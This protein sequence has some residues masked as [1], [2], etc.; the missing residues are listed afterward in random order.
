MYKDFL[1]NKIKN[2]K[3]AA[4]I[5]LLIFVFFITFSVVLGI[6]APMLKEF[7]VAENSIK[8]KQSYF[9]AE[10]GIEDAAYR[11]KNTMQIDSSENI[12]LGTNSVTTTITDIGNNQ[13]QILS[14]GDV[15]NRE[16]K[17]NM[18]LNTA[19]GV[20]FNYGVQ[21]GQGGLEFNGGSINGNV[22]SNGPIYGNGWS[23]IT[24]SATS[25][26][27][28]S[29]TTDQSNGSGTPTYNV[30]FA[31][32][33]AEQDVAQSFKI[34]N[35][36][37][38]ISKTTLYIKKNGAPS[39][40][41][42][43]I[44]NDSSGNPGSTVITSGTLSAST[45]STSYG[46]VEVSFDSN[47]LLSLNTTY[48]LVI[49]ASNNNSKYYTI[50]AS[51]NNY[52][53]GVGKIGRLGSSWSTP[54]TMD[55]F[56]NIF[57]GG[58]TG[59]IQSTAGQWNPIPIS[60]DTRAHNV[61][62]TNTTGTI[63]CTVDGGNNKPCNSTQPDPVYEAF[64][65][66]DTNIL[67]WK[68]EAEAGGTL[69]GNQSVG[70]AGATWGPKKINGNLTV[71]GGGVLT[72]TGTLWVTGTITLNGGGK[73]RLDPSYSTNDGIIVSDGIVNISGGGS[74][75]GSGVTGSYLVIATTN[76][77]VS[78]ISGGAGAVVFYA[79]EGTLSI[80]GGA[81]LKEATAYKVILDGG[82]SIT[83]E[84]GLADMSFNSGPSGSWSISSWKEAE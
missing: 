71:S 16:R 20:A 54:Q 62:Y 59:I 24:G 46:W 7:A 9:L 63:Y 68:N 5:T 75:T 28:P 33:S 49:D 53:N 45:V 38:G 84:S 35:D 39:N 3:G 31:K 40:A 67:D 82:S 70:W 65:I 80:S 26:N 51:G 21:V 22:Y 29:G 36:S 42:V 37:I 2:E 18:I 56:F 77:G 66:S 73:I 61:T 15:N 47:P 69:S 57:L 44:V 81:S 13:K 19:A 11:I 58:V 83:Y 30:V 23:A 17:S 8:S 34:T 74:A 72:L 41:T 32:T 52:A 79:S 10:S 76:S 55:L 1:K 14:A 25:A 4:M 50:G 27:G 64:P 43:K 48:W 12:V 78:S 6:V 60:G